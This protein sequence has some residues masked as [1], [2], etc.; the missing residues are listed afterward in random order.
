MGAAF[1]FFVEELRDELFAG[2][3]LPSRLLRRVAGLVDGLIPCVEL[4][5]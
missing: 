4:A 5:A 3:R 1:G 2:A